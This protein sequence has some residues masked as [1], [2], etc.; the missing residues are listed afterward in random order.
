MSR[1]SGCGARNADKC[2]QSAHT[3]STRRARLTAFHHGTC[4]REPT[5]PLSSRTRFL[6]RGILQALPEG[7][8][9]QSSDEVADRSSMPTGRLPVSRPG[10]EVTSPRPREPLLPRR[11]VS[12]GRRPLVSKIHNGTYI[13]LDERSNHGKITIPP[14]V[15]GTSSVWSRRASER[16]LRSVLV[17]R[18]GR[19]LRRLSVSWRAVRRRVQKLVF[20][21]AILRVRIGLRRVPKLGNPISKPQDRLNI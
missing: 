15:G 8:L 7:N 19:F 9:S 10:E 16:N 11:P 1:I 20:K 18:F 17:E 6:G 12:P 5:P 21:P 13:P 4:G 2:T 14:A 3:K